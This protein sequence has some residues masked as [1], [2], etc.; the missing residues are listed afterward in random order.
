[1]TC[2]ISIFTLFASP[3]VQCLS[4]HKSVVIYDRLSASN[5]LTAFFS[6]LIC[7]V[8]L[9]IC[10]YLS[11]SFFVLMFSYLSLS[12][13][14]LFCPYLYVSFV[15]LICTSPYISF[16]GCL[17]IFPKSV[18]LSLSAW[19]VGFAFFPSPH[20]PVIKALRCCYGL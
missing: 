15:V 9:I 8:C 1:M 4:V 10:P 18:C 19:E 16:F 3:Q 5:N 20:P 13:Y 12:V 17:L 2:Y 7:T 11:I 6:V 14:L